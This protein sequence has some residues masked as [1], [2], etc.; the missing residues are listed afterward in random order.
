MYGIMGAKD[1]TLY[2][3][4]GC[5]DHECMLEK[6]PDGKIE[7]ASDEILNGADGW[8]KSYNAKYTLVGFVKGRYE[9]WNYPE[10]ANIGKKSKA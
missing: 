3:A 2:L 6:V 4:T 5:S 1:A 10:A 9:R 8:I 7:S